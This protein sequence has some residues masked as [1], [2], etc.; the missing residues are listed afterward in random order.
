MLGQDGK[1]ITL[2]QLRDIGRETSEYLQRTQNPVE[3]PTSNVRHEPNLEDFNATILPL[4]KTA[5]FDCHG[6]DTQE[7]NINVESLDADL[8]HGQ[9]ASWWLEVYNAI[10]NGEMPPSDA[11]G[12]SDPD[13]SAIIEWL[14]EEL[15]VA[16]RVARTEGGHSSFRRLT[17]YE[18]NYAIQDLLGLDY[19]FAKDLPPESKSEDGFLNS[20][21]MLQFS[22]SQFA[23]Y[24]RIAREA[25]DKATVRIDEVPDPVYYSITMDTGIAK[26]KKQFA[27]DLEKIKKRLADDPEKLERELE[28]RKLKTPGGA[29]YRDLTTGF[30]ATARWSYGGARYAR[31]PT[32][33]KP[34][35]PELQEHIAVIPS[36]QRLIIDLGDHLPASGT[37]RLRIRAGAS[38][39]R[40]QPPTLRI[41][42]GHQASN[43]SKAEERV[44]KQDIRI[45][46]LADAPKFYE[47]DIPLGE[48]VRNPFRGVQKLGQT[49]NPAE[50]VLLRNTSESKTDIHIDYVEIAAPVYDSWPPAS[51]KRIL[52]PQSDSETDDEYIRSVLKR[53]MTKAWRRTPTDVEVA[54]KLQLFERQRPKCSDTQQTILEVFADVLSSPDFLYLTQTEAKLQRDTEL[55]TRLSIFLWSSLPDE[56]LLDLAEENQLSDPQTLAQQIERMLADPKSDRFAERFVS[57]WLNLELIDHLQIDNELK[58]A[59]HAEPVQL[60]REILQQNES[61]INF[62]HADYTMLNSSLA[63]HYGIPGV[64]GSEFRKVKLEHNLQARGGLLTLAGILAMNS[65]GEHSHP[66]KRGI[67]LLENILND[68]PPPPPPAVPEIDLTDPNILKLSLKE[69]MEDHRNDP[70][71]MSCHQRI[72]PWGIAFEN[73]G[74]RGEWRTMASGKPVDSSS[75]LF[76]RQEISGVD[77]L[78]RYLLANRQDQ[79]ARAITHKMT[80]YA[81]G[82]PLS[83]ADRAKV[84]G[85]T[86]DLRQQG[87]GLKTLVKLIATSDLFTLME[88]QPSAN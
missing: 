26:A 86:A 77:G 27:A 14:S 38:T 41:F 35:V 2:S 20:S 83:F 19:E 76:N 74:P 5:C 75:K 4:L 46:S 69:R 28:K 42:F 71:C 81:L 39:E 57:Q 85:I 70:A 78:K 43:N 62:L 80:A 24:R 11:E 22:G 50:Y 3:A 47:F 68:P 67:W 32:T 53:F 48:V 64:E 23:T 84:D 65:D 15:Q 56:E 51:H 88:P 59:M 45:T 73:F 6:A 49:P 31:T 30:A 37:M 18:Y 87:D 66:L 1:Q 21:E 55:A 12:L 10:S 82:R 9:D 34:A 8:V 44:G 25:L 79:F 16:S 72:D 58:E 13:R 61:I 33:G 7:G 29:Y 17:R 63:K 52:P 36:N 60:F 54:N 40:E